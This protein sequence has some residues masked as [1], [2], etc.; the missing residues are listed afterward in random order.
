LQS[1]DVRGEAVLVHREFFNS[2][3]RPE[4]SPRR[5]GF[6]FVLTQNR[7][8][9]WVPLRQRQPNGHPSTQSRCLPPLRTRALS[10]ATPSTVRPSVSPRTPMS[11]RATTLS[12]ESRRPDV[13]KPS[14]CIVT[15]PRRRRGGGDTS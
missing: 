3:T 11:T 5:A 13:Y 12:S 15:R 6:A 10:V 9:V 2:Q 1:L 14:I 7:C 8:P 4:I